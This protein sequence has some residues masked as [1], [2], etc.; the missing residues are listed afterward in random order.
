MSTEEDDFEE[1]SR[2]VYLDYSHTQGLSQ[3]RAGLPGFTTQ[4][5]LLKSSTML[6]H[7]TRTEPET[8][9][10]GDSLWQQQKVYSIPIIARLL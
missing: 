10:L 2:R 9:H 7:I 4:L 6:Y 3:L 8:G 5:D 1:T